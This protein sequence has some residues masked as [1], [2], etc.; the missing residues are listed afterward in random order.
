MRVPL[1]I[2]NVVNNSAYVEDTGLPGCFAVSRF[3]PCVFRPANQRNSNAIEISDF[4]FA[5]FVI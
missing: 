5:T 3:R 2:E 1:D 4:S